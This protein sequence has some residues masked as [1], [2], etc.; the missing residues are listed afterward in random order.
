M[1]EVVAH[2]IIHHFKDEERFADILEFLAD[3]E[4]IDV[5]YI[6]VPV[7]EWEHW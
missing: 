1:L 6:V 4:L 7:N 3:F 2:E 5:D